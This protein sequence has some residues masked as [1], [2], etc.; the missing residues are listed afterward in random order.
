VNRIRSLVMTSMLLALFGATAS[1]QARR[2]SGVVT[3]EAGEPIG[4]V[5]ISVLGTALG[6]YTNEAGRF[7]VPAP[8]GTVALRIRRIGYQQQTVTVNA[9]LNEVN[10][11]L[12]KDVL[13]LE[14]QVI[15]GAATSIASQNAANAVTVVT[16]D[17][18][19]R[20]AAP[21]LENALQGKV[22]GAIITTNSG[23]PGGGVQVQ[24]RGTTSIGSSSSPLYVVDGVVVSNDAI[25][26]GITTITQA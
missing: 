25:S 7:T 6:G 20:V 26:N 8:E 1:A 13:Q 14:K 19:N 9:A 5:S 2:I 23:A 16:G 15:T 21:T 17:Q 10:V 12:A 22:A 11:K 18:V 24:L 4:Q 3:N